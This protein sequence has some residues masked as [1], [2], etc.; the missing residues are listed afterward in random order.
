MININLIKYYII[1]V[2]NNPVD[3]YQ[4]FEVKLDENIFILL[5]KKQGQK[6]INR[7]TLTKQELKKYKNKKDKNKLPLNLD[8]VK[9][10]INDLNM[11]NRNKNATKA[12][13][14]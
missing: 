5:K 14:L 8:E 6:Y 7:T 3:Q 10:K 9:L 12:K 11:Y 13:I 2:W 1:L 4:P